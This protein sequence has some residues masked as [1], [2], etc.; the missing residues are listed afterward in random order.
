MTKVEATYLAWI[1]I[2]DLGLNDVEAHFESNGLG[3]S[4]GAPFG[5][6]D[7]IRFNFACPDV[8][9]TQGLERLSKA[10]QS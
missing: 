6:P 10:L 4:D 5:Q 9:L 3:I 1:N 7:Y 8:L 2:A